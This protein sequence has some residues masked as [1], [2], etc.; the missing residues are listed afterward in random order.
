MKQRDILFLSISVFAVIAFWIGFNIAHNL[1]ESKISAPIQENIIPISPDFDT[2]TI[3]TIK[4]RQKVEP[5]YE[6]GVSSAS[7]SPSIP[8]VSEETSQPNISPAEENP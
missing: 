1:D 7:S 6:T 3:E 2:K 4:S 5:L 8:V